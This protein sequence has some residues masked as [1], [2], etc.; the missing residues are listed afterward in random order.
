M[1]KGIMPLANYTTTVS[2]AKSVAEIH[3]ML[4]EHRAREILTN[5][6][7]DGQIE[8]LSFVISTPYGAMGIRLPIN[9]DAII[10]VLERQGVY[11]YLRTREQ[12]GKIAWRII[13]DW[14]R[15]QMAILETEMV[16]ME[17]IFLPYM[18]TPDNRTLYE[19][20]ADKGF[21][22]TEGKPGGE[23]G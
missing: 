9:L 8:S 4:V 14:V 1:G 16:K 18:I 10:K 21:Y 23:K 15:A 20:M 6:S 17:Q 5:Y 7:P 2:A 3:V 22:L 13:R 19:N 11:P 12:A